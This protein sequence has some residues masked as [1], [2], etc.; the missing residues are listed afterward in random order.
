MAV[1][2]YRVELPPKILKLFRPKRGSVRFRV[3]YGGRGSSKSFSFALMACLFGYAEPLRILCTR[4]LQVSIKESMHAEIKNAISSH[5]FLARFYTVGEN[6]IRGHNG[7]E[8]IFRGLRHNMSAIKSMAQIDLCIVEEAADVPRSSWQDLL[9]TIRADKSE[10]WV[11][12]NPKYETDYVDEYFRQNKPPRCVIHQLNWRDNPFFPKE[13]EEQRL[14]S[15][16]VLD[17]ATYEHIWE[18]AYLKNSDAQVFAN[19]FRVESFSINHTFGKPLYGLDFGF[20]KD[21]TAAICVYRKDN[22]L[23]IAHEAYKVGL[24]LD[25]TASYVKSLIPGIENEICYA[26]CA[27]PESISYLKRHGLPL[28]RPVKKWPGSVFDGISFIR[29]HLEIIVHP[30]CTETLK[31]LQLYSYK[32][33]KNT[34]E[35]KTDILDQFNHLIDSLRYSLGNLIK[36]TGA[37]YSKI[38]RM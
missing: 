7:T 25:D 31:E 17:P 16:E 27:R 6:F 15:K 26:D 11:V 38:T 18:G 32:V 22:T 20:A 2:T 13:L 8:F 21:P 14:Y 29:S 9:P 3:A 36:I 10:I 12:Y 28:I 37:D 19:K 35:I 30:R 34:G 1:L 4:E 33:D 24:E 5:P 23:Y